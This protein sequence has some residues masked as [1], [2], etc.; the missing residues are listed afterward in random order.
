MGFVSSTTRDGRSSTPIVPHNG[1]WGTWGKMQNCKGRD[2][3]TGFKLKV[4]RS[5]GSGDDTGANNLT[6]Q[7]NNSYQVTSSNGASWGSWS[8]IRSC[9]AGQA[10]SG[11]RVRVERKL[12]KG[13]DTALNDV[14]FYCSNL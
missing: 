4:E 2:F 11:L 9:P 8:P 12:G 1:Y 14:H 13:D 10:I 6:V 3:I 7:C 5:Q